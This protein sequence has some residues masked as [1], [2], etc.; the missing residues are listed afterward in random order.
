MASGGGADGGCGGSCRGSAAVWPLVA[1]CQ[2]LATWPWR[3][4][5]SGRA[6]VAAVAGRDRRRRHWRGRPRRRR[7][8]LVGSAAVAWQHGVQ[9]R[10]SVLADLQSM[11]WLTVC[12]CGACSIRVAKRCARAPR[13]CL[14][15]PACSRYGG[16]A[17]VEKICWSTMLMIMLMKRRRFMQWQ[18]IGMRAFGRPVVS[19]RGGVYSCVIRL[20]ARAVCVC[21]R[22]GHCAVAPLVHGHVGARNGVFSVCCCRA[23]SHSCVS[24]SVPWRQHQRSQRAAWRWCFAVSTR[25][26][27]GYRSYLM[28][29]CLP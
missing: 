19:V 26:R 12:R 24:Q 2:V 16:A 20:W 6:A 8:W 21:R 10:G 25:G 9:C 29:R 3:G 22:V 18:P 13:P 11:A 14:A 4:G 15:W 17:C 7:P 1:C 5:A 27:C 23:T 28:S